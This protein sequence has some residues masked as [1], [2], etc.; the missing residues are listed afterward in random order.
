MAAIIRTIGF[1]SIVVFSA[2][3]APLTVLMTPAIFGT[4]VII[5]PT[6]EMTFPTMIR[7]GARA[8]TISAIVTIVFFVPSSSPFN[9]STN[10]C[11]HPTICL[12]AGI[13]SSPNEMASPSNA[14][15]NMVICPCRLS[16]CVSAICPAAP[17]LSAID[18]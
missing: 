6:A 9:A 3:N 14:D 7:T 2:A 15:F 11:T 10:D 18:C 16:S 12:M 1:A 4:I 13:R 5:V 17:P 8:A